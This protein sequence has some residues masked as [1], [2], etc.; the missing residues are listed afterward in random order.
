MLEVV[1]AR[2][3]EAMSFCLHVALKPP[4][5]PAE[6]QELEV[7]PAPPN[8][9]ICYYADLVDDLIRVFTDWPNGEFREIKNRF[10]VLKTGQLIVAEY[11]VRLEEYLRLHNRGV[12]AEVLSDHLDRLLDER[13]QYVRRLKSERSLSAWR[14][15]H[16]SDIAEL[17]AKLR[18]RGA[19]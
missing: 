1:S 9:P 15:A 19:F 7:R 18:D 11:H 13:T 3:E 10:P 4:N 14:D 17:V 12:P 8:R 16:F 5:G 2:G 6:S